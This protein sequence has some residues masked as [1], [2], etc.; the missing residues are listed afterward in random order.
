MKK[1]PKA[2]KPQTGSKRTPSLKAATVTTGSSSK[3]IRIE[4]PI[5]FP[6]YVKAAVQKL[7][8]AGHVAYV[9]GGS[10]RDHFL[11]RE[12]KDHDIATSAHP[13]ELCELFPDAVTVG[14]AFGVIKVPIPAGRFLEVATF[15]EDLEY[16]DFRHPKKVRFSGVSEDASRRDFT[17][18]ALYYDLKTQRVFDPTD[19]LKDIRDSVVRAIGNQVARFRE[20]AL[21]LLR[22]V[23]FT[24]NLGFNLEPETSM[25]ISVCAKLITRVSLE[26][27][28]DELTQMWVG[29]SP[30]S[31]VELLSKLGLLVQVLPEIE[32][33]KGIKQPQIH[34]E[35]DVWSHTIRVLKMLGEQTK[36]R[37]LTLA[38]AAV[39]LNV[40]KPICSRRSQG[41]NFNGHEIEGT[42]ITGL[43][44]A[45][46]KLSRDEINQVT[47]LV[48]EQLKFR[49]VFK[50]RE[51]T[52]LRFIGQPD[53]QEH[54]A[55][56]RAEASA[57]DGNLAFYEFCSS[58]L[59]SLKLEPPDS[60]KLIDGKD[61]IQ[62]GL[63]PG[64]HFTEILRTIEDLAMEKKLKSKEDALEYVVKHFVR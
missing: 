33:Q 60:Q 6:V 49:D 51:S 32:Q 40:G 23:R 59:K 54:L 42:R 47:S 22:G 17:M 1:K 13:D 29:R 38:W 7:D 61:L 50:M 57:S 53:F 2:P 45:R 27:I 18:N 21:R 62:L 48:G 52:F 5:H 39:L 34:P 28:R 11:G 46:M 31:A 24:V 64:P 4:R 10:V 63:F 9:V 36:S 20:D 35:E 43:V 37:S 44:G 26:R 30:A 55:L 16:K 25:G 12:S 14:K 56:H 3:W 19:G 41:K 8:D 15:R 58:R